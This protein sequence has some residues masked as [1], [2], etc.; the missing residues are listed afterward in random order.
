[1]VIL[2]QLMSMNDIQ[3]VVGLNMRDQRASL[4]F[5]IPYLDS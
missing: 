1:M 4:S 3:M 5:L 2:V